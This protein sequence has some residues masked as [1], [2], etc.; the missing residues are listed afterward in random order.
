ML[1][2]VSL[3]IDASRHVLGE[4]VN[5]HG[6]VMV[7]LWGTNVELSNITRWLR[8]ADDGVLAEKLQ[9]FAFSELLNPIVSLA[10]SYLR[11]HTG[12]HLEEPVVITYAAV[13]TDPEVWS[14]CNEV[15]AIFDH[16][17]SRPVLERRD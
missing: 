2:C 8:R 13:K 15:F 3:E 4:L 17:L 9:L 14:E 16:D 1:A 5:V 7:Q 12:L 11:R 6:I 10:S